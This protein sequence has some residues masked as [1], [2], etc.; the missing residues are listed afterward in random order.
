[1]E[2]DKY[3]SQLAE[4]FQIRMPDGLRD[5]LRR[6]AERN[7]RSMNTEIVK[8]LQDTLDF[9]EHVARQGGAPQPSETDYGLSLGDHLRYSPA[10]GLATQGTLDTILDELRFLRSSILD[11]R[12]LPDGRRQVEFAPATR[13]D[14]AEPLPDPV[15]LP[16]KDDPGHDEAMLNQVKKFAERYGFDL[17]K[18][19]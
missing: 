18:K 16:A 11:V 14:D 7:G 4:R 13:A 10:P 12:H 17:V 15:L 2:D 19:N 1:M 3:P 5:A 6:A 9:D 8:R